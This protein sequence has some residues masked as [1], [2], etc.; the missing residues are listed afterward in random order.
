MRHFCLKINAAK[1]SLYPAEMMNEI[2]TRGH[3]R[4]IHN[5]RCERLGILVVHL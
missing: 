5:A 4:R 1:D 2:Q 3:W